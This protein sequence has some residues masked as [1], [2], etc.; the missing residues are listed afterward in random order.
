MTTQLTTDQ[1][2]REIEQ[3]PFAILGMVTPQGEA[4]TVG[5]VCVVDDH[6]L[7]IGTLKAAWKTKHI[8]HNPHVSLTIPIAKRLPFLPWVKIP[9]ATITFSGLARVREHC[10][11]SADL[12]RRLYRDVAKDA[13]AMATSCVIE[14]VP[15]KEFIT[16]G[17]GIP[18]MQMRFPDKARG[19]VAVVPG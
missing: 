12:L 18:L 11:V 17:V 3:N 7:Y 8:A 10:D 9:A 16:Y 14:V 6:K 5:V 4:R 1:V 15:Q 2:W 13:N 19:R